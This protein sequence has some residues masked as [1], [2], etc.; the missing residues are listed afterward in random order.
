MIWPF[1]EGP[2]GAWIERRRAFR[3][4]KQVASHE[5]AALSLRDDNPLHRAKVSLEVDDLKRAREFLDVARARIPNYVLTNPDTV[6]IL[7]GLRDFAEAD[8]FALSGAK[9]FPKQPHYLEGY[10][11]VAER[12]RNFDE[13]S[14]RWAIVRKK[15][16]HSK[17]GYVNAVGCLRELNRLD[18][19]EALLRQ[20]MRLLP[21][22]ITVL[23]EYCRIAEARADW[24]E[25]HRRWNSLRSRHPA[26]FV[27]AAQALQ[28]LNRATEAEVV[29]AEGR[30]RFPI[31][32]DLAVMEAR[33][34]EATGNM[35]EALRRWAVVRQRFPLDRAGYVEAIRLLREQGEWPDAE[36]VAQAAIERFPNHAWPLED[37]AMLAHV[38]K[39]WTEAA[40]RWAALSVAFPERT[41]AREREAEVLAAASLHAGGVAGSVRPA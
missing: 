19:A 4:L 14:R 33:I 38:R 12:Q 5:E 28:K 31:Y 16:P 30:F 24:E 22:D 32:L 39:D 21:D 34:A 23:F 13:A 10:A 7:I 29:L 18:E 35:V 40:K 11:L 17:L 8:A 25:A 15:F 1:G 3:D 37:Y 6:E 27:G 26:G 36:A 9:R 41:D 20:A 2:V